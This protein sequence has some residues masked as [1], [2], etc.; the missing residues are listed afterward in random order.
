VT[1]SATRSSSTW[2]SL[3]STEIMTSTSHSFDDVAS[4]DLHRC[5]MH[6][7]ARCKDSNSQGFSSLCARPSP[8]YCGKNRVYRP[9]MNGSTSRTHSDGPSIIASNLMAPPTWQEPHN[10]WTDLLQ[11]QSMLWMSSPSPTTPSPANSGTSGLGMRPHIGSPRLLSSH[12]PSHAYH[13]TPNISNLTYTRTIPILYHWTRPLHQLLDRSTRQWLQPSPPSSSTPSQI[14]CF[15][16]GHESFVVH[17]T[18]VIIGSDF[19]ASC[20]MLG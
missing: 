1:L 8:N 6:V 20:H 17:K 18:H 11:A 19:G 4:S 2:S 13:D 16:F 7:E 15:S 9:L 5:T 14:N 10:P 3:A 12:P